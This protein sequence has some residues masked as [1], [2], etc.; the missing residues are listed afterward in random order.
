[1]LCDDSSDKKVGHDV[2]LEI[3]ACYLVIIINKI[4]FIDDFI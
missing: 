3:I 2:R 1:M 4:E